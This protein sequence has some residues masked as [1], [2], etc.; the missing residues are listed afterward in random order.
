MLL[1]SHARY[2]GVLGPR[3]R[4]E[5]LLGELGLT[6]TADP[7]LHAPVGLALGAETPSEIA[8]AIV[9]EVQAA[10]ADADATQLRDRQGPIH[11]LRAV[12]A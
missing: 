11:E 12:G 8:L 4:T 7:R 2:L 9:A 3:R 1:A 6:G 5:R 10:L